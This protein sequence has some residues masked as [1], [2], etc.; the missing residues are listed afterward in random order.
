MYRLKKALFFIGTLQKVVFMGKILW[1]QA[2]GLPTLEGAGVSATEKTAAAQTPT[3][4]EPIIKNPVSETETHQDPSG[5][6]VRK[7]MD[8][9]SGKPIAPPTGLRIIIK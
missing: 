7:K 3:V 8:S 5:G 4:K 2:A 1:V 6:E 9:E